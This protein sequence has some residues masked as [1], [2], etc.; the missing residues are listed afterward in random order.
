M[1]KLMLI[2][3]LNLSIINASNFSNIVC[4]D[5][6]KKVYNIQISVNMIIIDD[7]YKA[8]YSGSIY[9]DDSVYKNS[10]YTYGFAFDVSDYYSD[11]FLENKYGYYSTGTC[12][13]KD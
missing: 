10:T 3:L 9:G 11:F 5:K 8:Y 2:L 4:I 1:N 7:K 12:R 13:L 6:N